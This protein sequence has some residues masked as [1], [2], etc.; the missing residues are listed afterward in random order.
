[1]KSRYK[2]RAQ[3]MEQRAESVERREKRKGVRREA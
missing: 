1:M 2:L 3:G